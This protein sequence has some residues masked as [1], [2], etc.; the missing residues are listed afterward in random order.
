MFLYDIT[1]MDEDN[2]SPFLHISILILNG[3]V[4]NDTLAQKNEKNNF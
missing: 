3:H 4:W 1:F 2:I